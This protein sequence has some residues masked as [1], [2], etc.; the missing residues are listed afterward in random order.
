MSNAALHDAPWDFTRR[1]ETHR[2]PPAVHLRRDIAA[3]ERAHA[4]QTLNAVNDSA[5][6][7]VGL[8]GGLALGSFLAVAVVSLGNDE[9]TGAILLK[10]GV[11]GALLGL[12]V[13]T[14]A[15]IVRR[16]TSTSGQ[17]AARVEIYEA[18]LAE[19]DRN[20]R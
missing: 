14:L 18:R 9:L 11:L 10:L 6:V 17:L 2:Y 13:T 8:A 1:H 15:G 3:Q 5:S 20:L 4:Q 16:H 12:S 7:R 19:I